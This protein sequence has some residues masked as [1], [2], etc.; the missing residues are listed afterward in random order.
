MNDVRT[1][2]TLAPDPATH[3]GIRPDS[4]LT[5]ELVGRYVDSD[6]WRSATLRSML[7]EAAAEHPGRVAAVDRTSG[8]TGSTRLTYAE[9]DERAHRYACGLHA[10]GVRA[11]D[12]VAVMLPNRADFAALVF[13]VN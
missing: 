4:R 6:A 3:P 2:T 5:P 8:G 11:G 13:A 7:A 12:F 10:L 1:R 9:L